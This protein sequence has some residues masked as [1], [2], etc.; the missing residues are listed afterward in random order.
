MRGENGNDYI[1]GGDGNDYT[2]GGA[3]VDSMVGGFGNDT[4]I[5]DNAGDA[6][7]K[8]GGEG[9]D[10]VRTSVS[11]TMTAGSD[12]ETL[13]TTSDAGVSAINLTGNS[14][15]NVVRGNAGNNIING[16][17]GNDDLTGLGGADTFRFNTALSEAFNID[18]IIDFSV[19]DDTIQLDDD[20]FS[21]SLTA[22][23]QCRGQPV[24]DRHG[25]ARR[26]RPYH[27][28]RHHRSGVLRQRR[29]G[30]GRADPVRDLE[31]RAGPHQLRLLRNRLIVRRRRM[32]F[33]SLNPSCV[34][35]DA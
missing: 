16:G 35:L 10:T 9:N 28:R 32:G 24:R 22:G 31:R 27:L 2:D 26:R 5:V 7:T 30:R 14:S 23:K 21:S 25:R 20:I 34:L 17:D 8:S 4:Y 13:R 29:R 3:G 18:H 33:A 6:V 15:G 12:I 19:T 11:W 1:E